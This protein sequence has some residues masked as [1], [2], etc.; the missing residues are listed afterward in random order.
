[1]AQSMV[2]YF[3][4]H[5]PGPFAGIM[6]QP[7]FFP[8]QYSC[9]Q[10]QG[11]PAHYG[12]ATASIPTMIPP[13]ASQ[14]TM[15]P[16]S[17]KDYQTG[18][19]LFRCDSTGD[20]YPVTEQP[21]SQAPVVLLSFSSTTWHRRLGHP[22]DDVLRRKHAKLSF[23]N[24]E[25]SVDSVFEII[26]SDIWT[27]PILSESGTKYYC[28][29]G[30][31]YD[32]TRFHD[33]FRQNGIQFW[34]SCPR[35]SQQN[36][37]SERM[38]CTINNLIRT[39]LFQAHIPLSYWV[40]ALNMA[41]HLLNILPS[42]AINN[43]IPFTKLYNQTPTYEHMRVFGCLCYPY[44]D[45]SHKLEPRSTPCIFLGYPANHRGYRC[46][47]LASKKNIISRYVL[48]DEDVFP[49]GNVTSFN[50]PTYDFLLPPIQTTT[51]VLTT[52]PFVQHMD[53]PNNPITPS[54]YNPSN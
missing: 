31:E 1:M 11:L 20:L 17:V 19:L 44:I 18:R 37:K 26:H 24:S 23:Y 50:K 25:S 6:G 39:L 10:A 46:L 38:L 41:A 16:F 21:S 27:S 29:H 14:A 5:A 3:N 13:Q 33:L 2:P 43:E 34:F 45:V 48:F 7:T 4:L 8:A 52:E 9:I 53:E 30:G 22:G 28:D 12:I 42:T 36:G 49:F 47:D 35:T 40:E 15:L 54:F 51:N 32:N